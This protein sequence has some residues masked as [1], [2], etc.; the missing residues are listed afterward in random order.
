MAA[1]G[2]FRDVIV[3]CWAYD[4]PGDGLPSMMHPPKDAADGLKFFGNVLVDGKAPGG[5]FS[6]VTN[7]GVRLGRKYVLLKRT[8]F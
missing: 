1:E 3:V 5:E 2:P 8:P 6:L 4:T 7:N